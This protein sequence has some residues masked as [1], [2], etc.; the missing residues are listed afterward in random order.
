MSIASDIRT[1]ADKAQAQLN[2]VTGQANVL[3]GKVSATAKENATV[4]TDKVSS[5]ANDRAPRPRRPSTSTPSR[6]PSSP[7][8]RRPRATAPPPPTAPRRSSP[9]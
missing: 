6:P 4:L 8:S 7:S 3:V 2:D 5:A 9:A 1:Y